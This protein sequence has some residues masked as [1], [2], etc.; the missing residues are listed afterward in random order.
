MAG[1]S[2]V[3]KVLVPAAVAASLAA[4][5]AAA[6]PPAQGWTITRTGPGPAVLEGELWATAG[7]SQAMVTMFALKGSGR[8]RSKDTRFATS[9]M[10]WGLDGWVRP[11]GTGLP[12]VDC[13][14]ACADPVG[15][16]GHL[17]IHSN[18]HAVSSVV[19]VAA[20][21]VKEVRIA[22]QSPGWR[23]RPWRVAMRVVTAEDAYGTGVGAAHAIAGTYTGASLPGGRYGSFVFAALPCDTAGW[24]AGTLSGWVAWRGITCGRSSAGSLGAPT[25]ATWLIEADGVGSGG[26]TVLMAVID[27]PP[28]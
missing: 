5:A 23:V 1:L 22:I 21:S 14:A 27:G 26:W 9:V 13:P 8:D 3:A 2:L 4:P 16:P 7:S 25:A 20:W 19:H 6:P 17:Y 18:G 28:G 12:T 10:Q 11:Y 15:I 24:G